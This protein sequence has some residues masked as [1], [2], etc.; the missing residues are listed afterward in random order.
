[1]QNL[2]LSFFITFFCSLTTTTDYYAHIDFEIHA[3]ILKDVS[4]KMND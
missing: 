4:N 3:A 2:H 1:M